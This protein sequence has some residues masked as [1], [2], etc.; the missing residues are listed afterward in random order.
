LAFRT[1]QNGPDA[2]G[3]SVRISWDSLDAKKELQIEEPAL[4]FFQGLGV[5]EMALPAAVA[6]GKK[7]RFWCHVMAMAT[8]TDQLARPNAIAGTREEDQRLVR[9]AS[10]QVSMLARDR[11]SPF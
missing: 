10:R 7:V 11:R 8:L 2:S 5:L 1:S 4:A 6:T 9:R 3:I